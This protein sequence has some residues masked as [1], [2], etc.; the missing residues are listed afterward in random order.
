M[1]TAE[2]LE[3][4]QRRKSPEEKA[5]LLA[6]PDY[7]RLQLRKELTAI[8]RSLGIALR[9]SIPF[10]KHTDTRADFGGEYH[11]LV[12]GNPDSFSKQERLSLWKKAMAKKIIDME[13]SG[14]RVFDVTHNRHYRFLESMS[15]T[16]RQL[17]MIRVEGGMVD[18]P[19][20]PLRFA[21]YMIVRNG[22][23]L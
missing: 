17:D 11:V 21:F 16:L 5:A 23:E 10:N 2:I 9:R 13:K 20:R 7:W 22:E 18:D 4:L 1:K 14:L 15:D 6:A 8:N 19:K 12:S 3:Q